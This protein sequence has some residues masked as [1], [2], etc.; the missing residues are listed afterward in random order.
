LRRRATDNRLFGSLAGLKRSIRASLCHFQTVQGQLRSPIAGRYGHPESRKAS[1]G[2]RIGSGMTGNCHVPFRS[3]A[4]GAI[5][6]LRHQM[7]FEAE[8]IKGSYVHAAEAVRG[9]IK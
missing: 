6:R 7:G 3:R 8:P 9:R 1:A 5:P 4:G 2:L